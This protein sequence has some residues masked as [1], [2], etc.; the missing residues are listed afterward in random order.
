MAAQ[1]TCDG[2][3]Q[4][5]LGLGHLQVV[6]FTEEGHAAQHVP[7][8]QNGGGGGEDIPVGVVADRQG[9][10]AGLML[11]EL[12]ALHDLGQGGGDA[13]VGELPPAAAGHGQADVPVGDGDHLAGGLVEGLAQLGGEV[14]QPA[15]EGV[16]LK[17]HTVPVGEDLQGVS[18]PDTHGSAD[19][20]GDDH[21]AQVV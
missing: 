8:G 7:L 19:L 12:A 17:H 9:G 10:L 20:F 13:L 18:L 15:H 11:V 4:L 2:L 1:E 21:P 6:L 3:G 5:M 14:P 16:F